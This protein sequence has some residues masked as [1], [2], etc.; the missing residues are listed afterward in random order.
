MSSVTGLLALLGLGLLVGGAELLVRGAAGLARRLGVPTLVIGLTIVSWGTA[1]PEVAVTLRSALG[2]SADLA[3]GNAV[4]SSIFN[5]LV[6]LGLAAVVAPFHV[7]RQVIRLDVP[8]LIGAAGA[9]ALLARDGRLSTA[10]G[11]LLCLAFLA[12]SAWLFRRGEVE[13]EPAVSGSPVWQDLLLLAVGLG[14]LLQGAAWLV[15]GALAVARALAVSEA[16]IGLTVLAAG[17][18]LPEVATALASARRG[19][20]ELAIGNA[21]GSSIYNLLLVL[22]LTAAVCGGI[23]VALGVLHFDLP[24]LLA[25]CLACLPVFFAAGGITRAE[26]LVMLGYYV[27]YVVWLLLAAARHDALP[28]FSGVMLGFVVP[29]TAIGV[30]YSVW[31]TCRAERQPTAAAPESPAPR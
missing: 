8:V 15:A 29:L 1:S 3:V 19:T 31:A 16:V 11:V 6:L 18:S 9:V 23:P 24:F 14:L 12:H 20:P 30:G 26:G 22:G 13:P 5:L 27:L 21:L 17:T 28:A 7:R 10:E 25:A 4:G 2:G